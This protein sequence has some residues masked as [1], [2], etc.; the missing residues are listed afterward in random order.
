MGVERLLVLGDE[1]H[2]TQTGAV[3]VRRQVKQRFCIII[4]GSH[5]NNREIK[6]AV[7]VDYNVSMVGMEPE[8]LADIE[9]DGLAQY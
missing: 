2:V 9:C 6:L 8:V 4:I 5:D 1:H 3:D 7:E